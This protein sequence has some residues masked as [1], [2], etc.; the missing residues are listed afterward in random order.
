MP[1]IKFVAVGQNHNI[2]F[3]SQCITSPDGITWTRNTSFGAVNELIPFW[4]V[5]N[6]NGLWLASGGTF[7]DTSNGLAQSPDAAVWTTQTVPVPA[8]GLRSAAF[9]AGLWVLLDDVQNIF[10]TTDFV[11]F[12]LRSSGVFEIEWKSVVWSAVVGLFVA[13][14]RFNLMKTSPDGITWT[15]RDPG[16]TAADDILGVTYAAG[17]FVAVGT[18]GKIATSPDGV[19]WTQRV[20]GTANAVNRVAYGAGHWVAVTDFAPDS[21]TILRSADAVT[22]TTANSFGANV[23]VK[24]IGFGF[25]LFVAVGGVLNTSANLA[26]SPD[27]VT[28]TQRTANYGANILQ[29]AAALFVPPP[30]P[31]PP[32]L[33]LSNLTV[34]QLPDPR[35]DC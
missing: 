5:V 26:T 35:K 16:F 2:G 25:N 1:S 22:W 28:W 6:G 12:T 8:D 9:G 24:G 34:V 10:T 20:S 30:V 31:L 29:M 18:S 4:D 13:G 21:L 33:P 7:D 3:G 23:D 32:S 15:D 17:Q 11:T 27:G 14:G 19:T